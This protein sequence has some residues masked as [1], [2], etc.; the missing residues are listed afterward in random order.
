MRR[1]K[2]WNLEVEEGSCAKS[3][4]AYFVKMSSVPF[5]FFA[6]K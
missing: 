4:A 3:P 1:A 5:L 6:L 2:G